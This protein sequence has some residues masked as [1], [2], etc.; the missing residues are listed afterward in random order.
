MSPPDAKQRLTEAG[1]VFE[2]DGTPASSRFGDVYFSRGVGLAEKEHVFLDGCDLP[3][4][5]RGRPAFTVCELGFGTGLT[6]LATWRRWARTRAPG[7]V[8]HYLAAEGY[9]LARESLAECLTAWP[10]LASQAEALL[11]VYPAPQRGF[12]RLFPAEGVVLTLMCGEVTTVLAR[13]E[14]AVDAWYLDGFAPAKN[15]AMWSPAVFREVARLSR[16]PETRLATY[17]A[18]GQVRRDLAEAGFAVELGQGFGRKREMIRARYAGPGHAAPEPWF[19]PATALKRGVAAVIGGGIAGTTMA[20]ALV[21]RGWSATIV[22]RRSTLAAEASGTPSGVVMPRLTA[23]EA[24]DGRVH[25]AAW[26]YAVQSWAGHGFYD[27][28]GVLQLATDAD[29]SRR[30]TAV[31]ASGVLPEAALRRLDPAAASEVAGCGLP[32][33]ALYFPD[34]GCIDTR[35]FCGSAA[36]GATVILGRA[37]TALRRDGGRWR[38]ADGAGEICIADCVVFANAGGAG[39][40]PQSDWLPLTARR[41]Q[42]TQAAAT[43]AS[44]GLRCVLAYGGTMLPVRNGAH[45]IGATF[46]WVKDGAAGDAT[47]AGDDIRNLEGVARVLPE[48]AVGLDPDGDGWAAVRWTSPDHLPVVGPLPDREAYA[49]D[50]ASLRHGQRWVTTP[51]ATYAPGLYVMVGF[52]S[53]GLVLAPLAAELLACEITGEPLPLERDLIAALHPARFLIRAIKRSK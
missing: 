11:R 39:A 40:F 18:A 22:E 15:P 42:I 33:S 29:E 12:H 49:R 36:T 30:Q 1:L 44:K 41:G 4:G 52:G 19:A 32:Y 51:P 16:G 10:E 7:A 25:A 5:W 21:R 8:L 13:L 34:G 31:A 24:I 20:A 48:L 17:T 37:V 26:R 50:Y 38:L 28:C 27:P 43:A 2:D 9:P 3:D 14:A 46:D 53:H 35:A 6:F 47:D 45:A 23:G